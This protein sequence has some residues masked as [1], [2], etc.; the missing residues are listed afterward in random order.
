MTQRWGQDSIKAG[1]IKFHT[2]YDRLPTARDFDIIDH[3]PSARQVQ[4]A[5]GVMSELRQRLGY[6]EIDY[7]KG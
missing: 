3:L 4:R 6:G 7:T 5:F 1:V 2:Q